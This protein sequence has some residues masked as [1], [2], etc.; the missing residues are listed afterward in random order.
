VVEARDRLPL[1]DVVYVHWCNREEP[2]PVHVRN[3]KLESAWEP[4]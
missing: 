4:N 3:I 2:A 1:K